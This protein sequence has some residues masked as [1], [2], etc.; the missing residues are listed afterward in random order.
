MMAESRVLTK[1]PL[2]YASGSILKPTGDPYSNLTKKLSTQT[3]DKK[4]HEWIQNLASV[5]H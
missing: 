3:F 1:F 2:I 5:K 4:I